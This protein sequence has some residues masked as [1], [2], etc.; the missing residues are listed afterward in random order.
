MMLIDTHI[1]LWMYSD[2]DM[3]TASARDALDN[4]EICLSI[5]SLW[6]LAI[7]SSLKREDKRLMIKDSIQTI[8]D[9]CRA[10]N[11]EIIPITPDDCQRIR[12][13][14][15]HHEDP[16]DRILIAQAINRDIPLITKDENIWKYDEVKTIW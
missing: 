15:H 14:P 3:L 6:E 12:S 11:I 10:Q 1:L 9:S 4:N 5:A 2:S 7:K 8:A 16:F 13:L